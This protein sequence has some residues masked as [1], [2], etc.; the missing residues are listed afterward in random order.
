MASVGGVLAL[1]LIVIGYRVFFSKHSERLGKSDDDDSRMPTPSTMRFGSYD[2]M[3]NSQEYLSNDIRTD[4]ALL[5]FRIAQDELEV[6]SK[7]ASGGYGSIFHATYRGRDVAVKQ[8]LPEKARNPA[9]LQSFMDEIR[10]CAALEHPRIVAFI[11]VAWSTL[12]D[13]AVVIEFMSRGDLSSTLRTVDS[14]H[15]SDWFQP[16]H[17]LKPKRELA[18]EIAEALVYL[19]SFERP[20]VHRDLKARNVLLDAAGDAKLS[21]FGVSRELSIEDTMTGDVGT[22]AWIAPE[23]LQGR[24]YSERAD[25]YSFGVLLVELDTCRHP[26]D[27]AA[28]AAAGDLAP[29]VTNTLIA[30]RVCAGSLAP[31]VS[32]QC[33][34]GVAALVRR[35]LSFDPQDRPTAVELHYELRGILAA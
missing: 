7:V 25:L 16:S 20:I 6:V 27:K 22:V 26:Y 21:D 8:I 23:V 32:P 18:L 24:Q 2:R 13:V 19:H 9:A 17:H 11:G 1:G 28:L 10:M 33:P 5:P 34:P 14:P 4:A 29:P 15:P 31:V 12:V 35:C 30:M 3:T